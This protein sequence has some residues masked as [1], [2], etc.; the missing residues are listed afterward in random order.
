MNITEIVKQENFLGSIRQV[1][2][3]EIL[4]H[5]VAFKKLS[6]HNPVQHNKYS[7]IPKMGNPKMPLSNMIMFNTLL[8]VK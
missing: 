3:S 4:W 6:N 1:F 7:L 5:R 8:N 2:N